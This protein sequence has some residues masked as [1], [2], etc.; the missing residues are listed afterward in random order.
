MGSTETCRF[1]V[2]LRL[3][4]SLPAASAAAAFA[5]FLFAPRDPKISSSSAAPARACEALTT[6][7]ASASLEDP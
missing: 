1:G 3:L 6:P 2:A 7:L 5:A 4:P